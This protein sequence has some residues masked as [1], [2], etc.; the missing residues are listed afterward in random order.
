MSDNWKFVISAFAVTWAVLI[1]YFV[2]LRRAH[3]RAQ[4]LVD[5]V[6]GTGRR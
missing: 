4:A 3:Q 1:A 2:H 5:S 6:A